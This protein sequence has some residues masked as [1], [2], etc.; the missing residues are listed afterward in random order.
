MF[1]KKW[2]SVLFVGSLAIL[3]LGVM[4][5]APID[6]ENPGGPGNRGP[7]GK[8]FGDNTYL[9]EALGISSDELQAA[10]EEVRASGDAGRGS[11]F[12]ALLA[13]ALGISPETLEAARD[14]AQ[15][16][17]LDQALADGNITQEEYDLFVARQ[18]LK[19]Y[20]E[21][22]AILAQALGISNEELQAA[23]DG[24]TRIP[25]LIDE[26]GIAQEDFQA[27]ME[28]AQEAAYQQA[29]ADG[30]ITQEQADQFQEE[31]FSNR[32]GGRDG[33]GKPEGGRPGNSGPSNGTEG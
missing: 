18:A 2:L 17:A 7:S 13:E 9:A 4:A 8:E 29:V 1:K 24:G 10:V 15:T 31:D 26:L 6:F 22:D 5:F 3:S 25:D 28:S 21:R 20:I 23:L 33:H 14:A 19:D 32:P 12:D 11:D 16:A 27:A 30:V